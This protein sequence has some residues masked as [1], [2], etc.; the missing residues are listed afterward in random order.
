MTS[1]LDRLPRAEDWCKEVFEMV[2]PSHQTAHEREHRQDYQRHQ[3]DY[4][5]LV[6]S[7]MPVGP[8]AVRAMP[9][10]VNLCSAVVSEKRHVQQAEHVERCDERGN[11]ADSP[12][13]RASLIR[14]PQN[15]ILAPE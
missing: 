8:V 10:R 13:D 12:I 1:S 15:F 14:L 2:A 7:A 5:T 4:W 11:H 3:H 9:V 6:R